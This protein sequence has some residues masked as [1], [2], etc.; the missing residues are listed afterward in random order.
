MKLFASEARQRLA[1]VA[2]ELQG[3]DALEIGVGRARRAPRHRRAA[4]HLAR[5]VLHLVRQHD[6]GRR[7]GDPAQHHR[8]AGP[9][10]PAWLTPIA[11]LL[12]ARADD[13]SPGLRD[14]RPAVDLGRGGAGVRA[15]GPRSSTT[16]ACPAATSACCS[17]TCPSTS[18][19]SAAPRSAGA[20]VVGI[21]P[22]RRGEELARDIRHT[23]CA[24]VLTDAAH[25]PLLEGLDLEVP[26]HLV[27]GR[28]L[29]ELARRRTA[30]PRSPTQLPGAG[31]AVPAD[32]HLGLHRRAQGGADE[33]GPGRPHRPRRRRRLHE[34]RRPL[35]LDAAVPR[36]RAARQ[37][38]PGDGVGRRRS[39]CGR[40]SRRRSSCPTSAATAA[41][42][43]TTSG[44]R[45]PTCSPSPSSPTTPTTR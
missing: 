24:V 8:R 14:R 12:V 38:V 34:R 35:L 40:G 19:C 16:S 20:V 15:R 17:T 30:A 28:G 23:D 18:S 41:P 1:L 3:A 29:D 36:Q 39:R 22:T 25:A 5:A 6:L 9:R 45:C 27:D 10:P 33:P 2:A 42:T 7:L 26:V 31:R 37:P 4:G 11:E 43:S 13:D 21:N 44:G 32:L